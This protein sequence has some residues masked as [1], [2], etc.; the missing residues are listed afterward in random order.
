MPGDQGTLLIV[1]AG[2]GFCQT[3]TDRLVR[4]R[5]QVVVARR[6]KEAKRALKNGDID[7][8]IL[9]LH[10]LKR[11]GLAVLHMIKKL[12][13]LTE[14]ILINTWEQLR[15]SME[16]M[17]LGAF[18][19][20]LMPFDIQAMLSRIKE[21]CRR[22]RSRAERAAGIL[23][24]YRDAMTACAFAEAGEPEMARELFREGVRAGS[25]S[26]RKKENP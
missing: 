8:V 24:S 6:G 26:K 18:D 1:E 14:V 11:D 5:Y 4:E 10:S 13:P 20:F 2:T 22:K 9:G 3:L 12:R 25:T 16:A 7:V 15:L 21:A 17:K 23:G 19:D